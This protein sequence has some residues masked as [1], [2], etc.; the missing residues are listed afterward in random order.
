M[1]KK[2]PVNVCPN[3]STFENMGDICIWLGTRISTPYAL[4]DGRHLRRSDVRASCL[5]QQTAAFYHRF[6]FNDLPAVLEDV[7]HHQ[8]QHT[9]FMHD[10]APPHF[11]CTVRQHLNQAFG[12]LWIE[13]GGPAKWPARSP[14]L[15]PLEFWLCG[16]LKTLVSWEPIN[17]FEALQ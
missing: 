9:W 4:R 11:L 16:R 1:S 3:T 10:G 15:N 5:T 14:Y 6:M 17:D 13:R 2:I 7:L 12:G 8:W